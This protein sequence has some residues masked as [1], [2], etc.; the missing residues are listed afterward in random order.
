[1][2]KN[3]VEFPNIFEL[4]VWTSSKKTCDTRDNELEHQSRAYYK[5]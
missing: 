3:Q 2:K 4:N 1:M 5:I